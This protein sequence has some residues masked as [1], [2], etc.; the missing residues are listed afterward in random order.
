VEPGT[1]EEVGMMQLRTGLLAVATGATL[2]LGACGDDDDDDGA[3]TSIEA[4]A[5]EFQF[6]PDS[7][8][9]PAGEEFTIGFENDGTTDHEWAVI[10]L[11]DDLESEDGFA[12][13]KVLL[14]V[15]ALPAGESTE[16]AFTIDEAG[17]YQV[18]CALEGHFDAGMEGTLTVE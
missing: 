3:S 17:T 14:E 7:W 13:D 5:S 11:G 12:E 10:N 6:E 18:I 16:Q 9:V 4:T 8:T 15:E 2:V 1:H